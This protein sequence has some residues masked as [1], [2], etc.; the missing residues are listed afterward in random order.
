MEFLTFL[1]AAI[2]IEGLVEYLFKEWTGGS[3]IKYVALCCG[4]IF[5][6]IYKLDLMAQF[7]FVAFSPYVGYVITG[8]I[9]GRGSNYVNDFVSRLTAKSETA[10]Q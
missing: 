1:I 7:G 9:I 5:A 10:T 3:W 4:V 2:F 6:V 8:L